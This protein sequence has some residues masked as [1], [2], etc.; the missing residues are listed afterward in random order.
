LDIHALGAKVP[1]EHQ[2]EAD[3]PGIDL[4]EKANKLVM[5]LMLRELECEIAD[6]ATAPGSYSANHKLAFTGDAKWSSAKSNPKADIEA[7]K[8]VIRKSVG[9]RPNVMLLSAAAYNALK[10]HPMVLERYKYTTS[11][12]V[13]TDMLQ[14]L[15]DIRKIVVGEM[16]MAD[17]GKSDALYDVWGKNAVLA[18]VPP[19]PSSAEE[20]SYAY[21]YTMEGHPLTEEPYWDAMHLSWIY[22]VSF[23]RKPVI[24]GMDAGFLFQ[25]VG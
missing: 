9:I 22:R 25:D 13:T 17:E 5:D 16:V 6:L 3:V 8:E 1:R 2:R 21:T 11:A 4:A 20:P 7:A 19:V 10:D 24:A 15:F 14:S 12:V 23:E 18:Y